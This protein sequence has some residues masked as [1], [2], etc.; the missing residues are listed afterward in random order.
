VNNTNDTGAGSLRQAITSANAAAGADVIRFLIPGGPGVKTIMVGAGGLPDVTDAVLIDGWTATG[1]TNSPLIQLDG[2]N[3]A[4]STAGINIRASNCT[5]RGLI[6]HSFPDEGLEIDG[7]TA[8]ANGDNNVFEGN[9]IGINSAGQL[10]PNADNGILVTEDSNNNRIGGTGANQPN[11]I[12]GSGGDGVL[13]RI[14]SDNNVVQG[15]FIGVLADGVTSRPNTRF[16]VEILDNADNNSIG[17]AAALAANVIANSGLD[18]VGISTNDC[19]GV[20]IQGNRIFANGGLGIDLEDNGVTNNDAGDVDGGANG[21]LNFPV[22]YGATVVG[23][24]LVVGGEARPGTTVEIFLAAVDGSGHGEAQTFIGR[25]VVGATAGYTDAT[26][27]R[28]AF[29]FALGAIVPGNQVAAT[30]IDG[31]NNT[32]EF[33][34]NVVVE[35]FA[36]TTTSDVSSGATASIIALAGDPGSDL[37]VSLREAL[38]A[39]NNTAGTDSINFRISAALVGGVHTITPTAALPSITG[40]LHIT[41][42]TEPDYAGTPVVELNGTS[43]GGGTNGLTFA[44]GSTASTLRALVINRFNGNGVRLDAPTIGIYGN[45]I[46]TDAAGT[47]NRGNGGAGVLL[48]STGAQV[49]GTAAG[50]PNIIAFNGTGVNALVTAGN[51]NAVIGNTIRANTGIGI[52]L[53]NN[54]VTN[55]DAGDGDSGPNDLLNFP[56]IAGAGVISGNINV[57]FTID[58]PAA[59]YRVDFFRN[60]GGADPSGFGEGQ[61]PAASF[62]INHPGGSQAYLRSF[63]GAVGEIITPTATVCTDG[64][65]CTTFGSTSE[66]GGAVTTVNGVLAVM[67]R[68]YLPGGTPIATGTALPRG[69]DV[70]FVLYVN[71]PGAVAADISLDDLLAPGFT[72][73]GGTMRYSS[74]TPNC[75][76][77]GCTPAQEATIYTAAA[78]GTA[79]TEAIDGDVVSFGASTVRVGNQNVANA[80]LNIPAGRVWAVLFRVRMQ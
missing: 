50:A 37:L 57:D 53:G 54:G 66:F 35:R 39:T 24:N 20:L 42:T 2:T 36:V 65:P 32:S 14:N 12:C 4:G 45:R 8:A 29:T 40:V 77:G 25:G 56:A 61:T 19:D 80:Q 52:D 16:G 72:Y 46:G 28:F 68:A 59:N 49:G 55:N 18:G 31:T 47:V 13:I 30:A 73:I 33:S 21:R 62:V 67:K 7:I 71:N 34:T 69:T 3:A 6:V 9:W 74:T 58:A 17:G 38:T 23:A 27:R 26:A 63:P 78:A 70:D 10:R 51:G 22:I 41:G 11:I 60:P 79:G 44:A 15:N 64:A 48:N 5:V 43:A 75:P 76:T 1:F